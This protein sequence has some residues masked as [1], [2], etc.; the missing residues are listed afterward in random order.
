MVDGHTLLERLCDPP[1][2][3][4]GYASVIAKVMLEHVLGLVK[5]YLP[6]M[7]MKPLADGAA[8]NG[9]EEQFNKYH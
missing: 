9:I 8:A 6:T 2:S 7:D 5:S 4:A 3:I 1:W